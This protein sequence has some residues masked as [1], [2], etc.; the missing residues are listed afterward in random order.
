MSPNIVKL[1]TLEEKSTVLVSLRIR[2]IDIQMEIQYK[3][4]KILQQYPSMLHGL[5]YTNT[6]R[7]F[8]WGL[9]IK[10]MISSI[11]KLLC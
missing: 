6:H 5:K 3:T 9:E 7:H 1:R 2:N 10:N 4:L 8:A 11:V